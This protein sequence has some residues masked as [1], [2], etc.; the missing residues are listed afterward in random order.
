MTYL[1]PPD[2]ARAVPRTPGIEKTGPVREVKGEISV[3]EMEKIQREEQARAALNGA[4]TPASGTGGGPSSSGINL[5]IP[6]T[7]GQQAP[8]Q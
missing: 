6:A 4:N 1:N 5:G 8:T 3:Q 7:A 2:G